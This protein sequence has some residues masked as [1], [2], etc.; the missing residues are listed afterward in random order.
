MLD[1]YVLFRPAEGSEA[2][3]G[4][5]LREFAS[6]ITGLACVQDLTWGEN[7]NASGLERGFTHGCFVRLTDEEALRS[8]Y[9]N[10]PAHQKLLGELER[11]HTDRFA[12]D[13]P[14]TV[15]RS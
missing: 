2:A 3:L 4:E 14:S 5:A 11:L 12:V 10:H 9:W 15:E 13:Y 7:T 1:H 8:A 6:V